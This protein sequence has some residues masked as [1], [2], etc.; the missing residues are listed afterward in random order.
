MEQPELMSFAEWVERHPTKKKKEKKDEPR[1]ASS[2]GEVWSE[3]GEGQ[4]DG[5]HTQVP[6]QNIHVFSSPEL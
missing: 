5:D 3:N 1:S 4:A 6:Q 2:N